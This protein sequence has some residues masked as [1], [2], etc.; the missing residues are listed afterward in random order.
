MTRR[1]I[2]IEFETQVVEQVGSDGENERM[3]KTFI[4]CVLCARLCAKHWR[5]KYKNNNKNFNIS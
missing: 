4:K 3:N 1:T 2:Q 5:Y